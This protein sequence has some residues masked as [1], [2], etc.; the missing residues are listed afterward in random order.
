[1][2]GYRRKRDLAC[3]WFGS[4]IV[5]YESGTR[6]HTR[7][8]R[9]KLFNY[10]QRKTPDCWLMSEALPQDTL[11]HDMANSYFV[12]GIM[13]TP[14]WLRLRGKPGCS[15]VGLLVHEDGKMLG[16]YVCRELKYNQNMIGRWDCHVGK[17]PNGEEC[18]MQF[19]SESDN[20]FHYH[21]IAMV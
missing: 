20:I 11:L 3:G 8:T 16:V 17:L 13:L 9:A 18:I 7:R 1:M 15:D 2:R 14:V 21:A 4:P 5:R 19:F 10:L 6:R 12:N